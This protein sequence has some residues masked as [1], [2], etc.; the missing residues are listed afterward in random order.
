MSDQCQ[1]TFSRRQICWKHDWILPYVPKLFIKIYPGNFIFIYFRRVKPITIFQ[2][3]WDTHEQTH[4]SCYLHQVVEDFDVCHN[5]EIFHSN[6]VFKTHIKL[7]T[8]QT[9]PTKK[10]PFKSL[11]HHTWV[12]TCV[13]ELTQRNDLETYIWNR[14]FQLFLG[15]LW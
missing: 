13:L 4:I 10:W 8:K 14:L 7:S 3:M 12:Q 11:E 9:L 15:I 5:P 1:T 6:L 2:S